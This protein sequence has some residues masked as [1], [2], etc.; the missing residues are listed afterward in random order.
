MERKQVSWPAEVRV[1]GDKEG[2]ADSA[3]G[4]EVGNKLFLGGVRLH[5]EGP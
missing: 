4:G 5:G 1:C 2:Q 3:C